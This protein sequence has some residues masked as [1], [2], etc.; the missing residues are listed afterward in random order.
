MPILCFGGSFNPI[1]NAHLRCAQAVADKAGYDRVLLIPSAQPPHK[2]S[3]ADLAPAQHRVAMCRLAAETV[4][5]FDVDDLETRRTGP[6]YTLDTARKLRHRR[7]WSEVH[8]LIGGDMLLFLPRWHRPLELLREVH[9]VVMARP[10]Y[11]IN[12]DALPPEYHHLRSHQV[13]APMVD[14][15]ATKIRRRVKAGE[16]IDAFVPPAVSRYISDNGLYR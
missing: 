10:G 16:S 9:F 15:S 5:G 8:W 4:A 13:E 11:P 1:H 3:A 7:G 12:W 6:S 14:I 2:P